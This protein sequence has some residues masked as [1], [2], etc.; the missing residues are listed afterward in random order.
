MQKNINLDMLPEKARSELF[1][2]YEFLTTKYGKK[3]TD[4]EKNKKIFL[5][6]VRDHSF[7]LPVGYKFNREEIYEKR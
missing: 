4:V 2:F 1:D 3:L 7:K 6:S 5:E